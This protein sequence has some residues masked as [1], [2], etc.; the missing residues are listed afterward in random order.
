M[1]KNNSNV[2]YFLIAANLFNILFAFFSVIYGFS[3]KLHFS[4]YCASAAYFDGASE[5]SSD[6][7]AR[8]I[9][10]RICKVGGHAIESAWFFSAIPI[11]VINVFLDSTCILILKNQ[12]K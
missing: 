1:L 5:L 12:K 2:I 7:R 11:I 4:D 3:H 8:Q 6:E 9:A 10:S